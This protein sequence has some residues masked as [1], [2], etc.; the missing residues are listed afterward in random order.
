MRGVLYDLG[1]YPGLVVSNTA[2]WVRGEVYRLA[3]ELLLIEL[4]EYEGSN[5]ERVKSDAL[6]DSGATEQCWVYVY[7]GN[8]SGHPAITSGDYQ[9]ESPEPRA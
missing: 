9:A 4:D 3:D 2:G 6:L 5:F 7:R 8:V 1:K